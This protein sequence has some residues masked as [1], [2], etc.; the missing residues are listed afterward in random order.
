M[1]KT[2]S[3]WLEMIWWTAI[4]FLFGVNLFIFLFSLPLQYT[5][6]PMHQI[7][8]VPDVQNKKSLNPILY[9]IAS[10]PKLLWDF[11]SKLI[12]LKYAFNIPFKIT[13]KTIIMG[14]SFQFHDAV[15]L[16]IL[17]TLSSEIMLRNWAQEKSLW[18][19]GANF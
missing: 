11:I 12:N 18:R 10:F 1:S 5:E 8:C 16:N 13:F 15:Q 2:F 17:P 19:P 4:Y 6:R 7:F 14:T 3:D 9:F